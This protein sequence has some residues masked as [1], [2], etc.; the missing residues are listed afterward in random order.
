MNKD[1]IALML[2]YL[3]RI[4]FRYFS[5]NV[6]KKFIWDYILR[7]YVNWREIRTTITTKYGFRCNI[8]LPDTIQER[9]FYFGVWEPLMSQYIN[10]N[11]S[12]GDI[13]IDVG[14]NIGY[15]SCLASKLVGPLGCVY[16]IEASPSIHGLLQ[17]NIKLN[18]I[19]NIITYNNAVY[20]SETLLKIYKASKVNIGAT[21][22]MKIK[23]IDNSYLEEA[24][25][26]AK[27]LNK[28]VDLE[29]LYKARLI[30]ID[31][32]GAEW[33]VI[34]GIKDIIQ[35]FGDD[36]EWLIEITPDDIERQQGSVEDILSVFEGNGYHLY[37]IENR[38][39]LSWYMNKISKS[40]PKPL[41][42]PINSQVD[43]LFTKKKIL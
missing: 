22:T 11:L 40:T 20:N 24:E 37:E 30:K 29:E 12:E 25:V 38:Y 15:Y 13:F 23:A 32:E 31:V 1:K 18:N 9:I 19:T 2:A 26:E 4:Y 14:A 8:L 28:I 27:P 21:T 3:M 41:K 10:D 42:K 17:K 5:I 6:G 16:S 36:T 39:N 34:E 43:I 35:N 33:F 7:P